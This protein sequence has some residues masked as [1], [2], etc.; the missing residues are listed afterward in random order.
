MVLKEFFK[1]F[2]VVEFSRIPSLFW[3]GLVYRTV[4]G[5]PSNVQL[6][7]VTVAKV[8]LS[9]VILAGVGFKDYT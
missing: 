5:S 7:T 3:I 1:E 8:D 2:E 6:L 4:S 9:S